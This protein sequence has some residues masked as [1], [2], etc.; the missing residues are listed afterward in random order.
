MRYAKTLA[1]AAAVAAALGAAG[2]AEAKGPPYKIY[3]S[4][5]YIGNDW[6]AES[7]NMLKAMASSK[8]YKDKV[9]LH[10]QVAGPSAQKQSQQI[11]AMVQ[12]GADAIIM[13]AVSGTL[14]NQAIRNACEKGVLVY[15]YDLP[16]TE[17]CA[18]NISANNTEV[19]RIG[20]EWLAE[21]LGGKGN[22]V[23][24][25]GVPG[26]SPDTDR[27]TA[28][29]AVFAKYPGIKI[30]AEGA[31]M[32][33]Q[34]VGR[35]ELSK[36]VA[37]HPWSEIDGVWMQ[38]ACNQAETLMDEAGIPDEKKKPC[39]GGGDNGFLVQLLPK[40]TEVPGA[41]GTYRPMGV[42]GISIDSP[43]YQAA[44]ALKV[45]VRALET[46]EKS[47]GGTTYVP[48]SH[49]VSGE[50]KLC[51]DGT[52]DEMKAGCNAFAPSIIGNPGWFSAIYS[53]DTPEVGLSAAL[54]GQ[55]EE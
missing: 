27:N 11:N 39:A 35:Q 8:A 31:G 34:A 50:A 51:K 28:A 33:S 54:V 29:K 14:L 22:I 36:I 18:N 2:S 38:T 3:L 46:G 19:G 4:M 5:S 13:Y 1:A 9:D 23:M 10:V 43:L 16:V 53:A 6:Q 52:W 32:W 26:T 21:K 48:A 44:L 17:P 49:A 20:A 7:A 24:I 42:P 47:K 55:P 30:V 15:T 45:A 12:A 25:N 37:T 40:D 41:N